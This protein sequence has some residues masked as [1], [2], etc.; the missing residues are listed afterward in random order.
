MN[1]RTK[2]CAISKAV[3]ET[4]YKRDRGR[5]ILCG[6][7]GLPEAHYIPRSKG[8]LGIEQNI[9]TLCR[10]CHDLMDNTTAR[11]SLRRRVKEHLDLWYPN[12]SD[13]DRI[14]KKE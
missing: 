5:C 2:A 6:R 12:F 14:Y 10:P 11:E 9:V 3:K 1:E 4:V 7:P 13:T 8:G